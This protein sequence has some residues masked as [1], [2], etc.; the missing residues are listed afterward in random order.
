MTPTTPKPRSSPAGCWLQIRMYPEER[1]ALQ[2][3]ARA[4][5]MSASELVR[6]LVAGAVAARVGRT[7]PVAP[8]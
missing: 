3:L 6:R 7:D 8:R 4:M 2:A 5:D 1:A